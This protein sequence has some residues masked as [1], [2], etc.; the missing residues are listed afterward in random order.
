MRRWLATLLAVL[1]IAQPALGAT[2]TVSKTADTNDGT[3]DGDCSLREAIVAANAA[4]GADTINFTGLTGTITL[5]SA[6]TGI[7]EQTTITGP[8]TCAG[9]PSGAGI[10]SSWPLV[11]DANGISAGGFR[12]T[13]TADNST[14]TGLEVTGVA[15]SDINGSG[16]YVL[17]GATGVTVR[18]I[19]AHGN[20]NG[21]A[22]GATSTTIGGT[23]DGHGNWI[24]DNENNGI[25]LAGNSAAVAGNL[26]GT[27]AAGTA[28]DG[29]QQKGISVESTGGGGDDNTIGG[30]TSASRNIIAGHAAYGIRIEDSGADNNVVRFD[31]LGVA[32]NG[33]TELCNGGADAGAAAQLN[34]NGTGTTSADNTVG[35]CLPAPACC[36]VDGTGG[37]TCVDVTI[38]P[39]FTTLAECT[40]VVDGSIGPGHV[41]GINTSS[42]C[43]GIPPA[44]TCPGSFGSSPSATPKRRLRRFQ[45]GPRRH[46]EIRR[47]PE[48]IGMLP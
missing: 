9:G 18:C 24:H 7:T 25:S 32:I 16:I 37:V 29:Q 15:G 43:I 40:A 10:T 27:N 2:F 11:I 8:A 19:N 3:C 13:S 38:I 20:F 48:L 46:G 34:D 5:G 21:I 26:I 6:L 17:S 1:L 36:A 42:N 23:S 31:Y 14:I 30:A 47:T 33:T 4:G 35:E 41:L 12:F 39:P 22:T 44:G 28:A 45:Q